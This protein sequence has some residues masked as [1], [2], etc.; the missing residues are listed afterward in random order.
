MDSALNNTMRLITGCV[1]PI[2]IARLPVLANI[3][4][5][6]LCRKAASDNLLFNIRTRPI[7]IGH[8]HTPVVDHLPL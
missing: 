8:L 5:L 4:P 1:L 3:T 2:H 7:H 6:A